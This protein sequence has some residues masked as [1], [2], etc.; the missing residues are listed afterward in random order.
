M[1]VGVIVFFTILCFQVLHGQKPGLQFGGDKKFRIVQ[2]TDTHINAAD[3]NSLSSVRTIQLVLDREKPDLVVFT[4]DIAVEDHPEKGWEMVT[5][6]VIDRKIPFAVVFGNHDDEFGLGRSQLSAMIERMPYSLF[7]P[8]VSNITGFGNYIIPVQASSG[9]SVSALLYF[10]DSNAYVT[11]K[12]KSGYNWIQPD[13]IA[14]YRQESKKWKEINGKVLPALA[15]FHIPLP[16]F[17]RAYMN[18]SYPPVGLRL[19]KECSPSYNSGM[20]RAMEE[21]GDITGVFTGHDHDNDYLAILRG[22]ALGYGRF[23]GSKTTYGE[24]EN[25]ARI[26]ELRE[27]SRSFVTWIRTGK[28][29]VLCKVRFPEDFVA[30]L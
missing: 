6:P 13:Q 25:G 23:T 15:F 19:E 12:S 27:G 20:F 29:E 22:I 30:K 21:C 1:K 4:G 7:I 18:E 9:D 3:T 14:W 8:K 17:R 2:F 28:D 10:L 11:K 26:I 5:R 24:L 16:E